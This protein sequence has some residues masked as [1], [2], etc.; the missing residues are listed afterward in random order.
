MKDLERLFVEDEAREVGKKRETDID[1]VPLQRVWGLVFN[2]DAF[3]CRCGLLDVIVV[4][5]FF[6]SFGI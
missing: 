5:F 2:T 6:L 1:E 3:I 4:R